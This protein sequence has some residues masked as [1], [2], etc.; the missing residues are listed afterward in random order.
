MFCTK[1]GTQINE[2]AKFC[3]GCGAPCSA[4]AP[5]AVPVTPVTPAPV[6]AQP[7]QPQG[8]PLYVPVEPTPAAQPIPEAQPSPVQPVQAAPV[9]AAAP[10][11][12]QAQYAPVPVAPQPQQ[13][14]YYQ[15]PNN[16]FFGAQSF[17]DGDGLE[18]LGIML[19]YVLLTLITLGIY[20]PWGLCK[21][22]RWRA[23]H[24]VIQGRRLAFTGTGGQ[25]FLKA[26]KWGL[27]SLITFGIYALWAYKDAKKWELEHTFY[28]E[29]GAVIGDHNPFSFFD[30]TVG[31]YFLIV[32]LGSLLTSIT[33]GIYSPWL[34]CKLQAFEASHSVINGDRLKFTG[35]GGELFLELLIIALLSSVT[36]GIYETWGICR[37]NR[38]IYSHTVVESTGNVR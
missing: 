4:P 28:E 14:G 7:A 32:L 33:C 20:M 17:F 38:F 2:G 24:T 21:I 12:A 25:L 31:E 37:L 3:T 29:S 35:T 11:A 22:M 15:Q 9:M 10:V 26:L 1:C 13:N 18:L 30:G 23:S 6:A 34:T 16:R 27:L 5:A 8:Q 36:C 19:L